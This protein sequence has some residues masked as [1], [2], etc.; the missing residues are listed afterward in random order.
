M[1]TLTGEGKPTLIERLKEKR[2]RMIKRLGKRLSRRI[3]AIQSRQSLVGNAPVLDNADFPFLKDFTDHWEEIRDE[4]REILKH[5]EAVPTFQDISR[6]QYRI[7]KGTSWRTF[8]LFGFGEKLQK[9]CR[10]A[11]VT[12]SVLERVPNLQTAW[13]S[14]LAPGYHIPAHKGVSKGILRSHLG[15]IIPRDAEKCRMRVGEETCVWREGEIFVFD[16]TYE[17][18]VWND[19]EDE[20]VILLFDFDRPMRFWGRTLNK[21]FVSLLKLTAYYQEPKRKMENFEDRFEAA[22]RR[23]DENLE[24]LSDPT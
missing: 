6:D 21:V 8:I 14:I 17:H 18:E 3:E 2:R 4:V 19:T 23:A 9:N 1:S 20:R 13:F 7:A 11:P 5:R 22:T 16:D 10:Q 24:K 15:L 12:A